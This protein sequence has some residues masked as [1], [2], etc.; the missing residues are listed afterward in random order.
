MRSLCLEMRSSDWG[1]VSLV[2]NALFTFNLKFGFPLLL[3][4]NM[5][6]YWFFIVLS[7][8]FQHITYE[9]EN[10]CEL[11][12]QPPALKRYSSDLII[13]LYRI[14]SHARYRWKQKNHY[15][16]KAEAEM[17][18]QTPKGSFLVSAFKPF[19]SGKSPHPLNCKTQVCNLGFLLSRK[20]NL[21]I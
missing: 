5:Y 19:V 2:V 16:W 1:S 20:S 6:M 15:N 17:S 13:H 7:V 12:W 14:R 8:E 18:W 11:M 9:M 21:M 3:W 4:G 10:N